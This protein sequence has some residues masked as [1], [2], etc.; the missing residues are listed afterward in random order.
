M[1]IS[2]GAEGRALGE[3][4]SSELTSVPARE[5]EHDVRGVLGLAHQACALLALA[6]VVGEIVVG[7]ELVDVRRVGVDREGVASAERRAALAHVVGGGHVAE[8]QTVE[9]HGLTAVRGSLRERALQGLALGLDDAVDGQDGG[10]LALAVLLV[11]LV[12][13]L[14]GQI[15]H[16]L[17]AELDEDVELAA[18]GQ[19][20]LVLVSTP[21]P[22][23]ELGQLFAD[24]GE[25][26]LG[27]LRLGLGLGVGDGLLASGD[28]LL[29]IVDLLGRLVVGVAADDDAHD[30]VADAVAHD[31]GDGGVRGLRAD[32]RVALLAQLGTDGLRPEAGA[33]VGFDVDGIR[34]LLGEAL[35][36]GVEQRREVLE[37]PHAVLAVLAGDPGARRASDLAGLG[38]AV[39][40]GVL[41][42]VDLRSQRSDRHGDGQLGDPGAGGGLVVHGV[43][44]GSVCVVRGECPE[45]WA[46]GSYAAAV[47]GSLIVVLRAHT[48]GV[49]LRSRCR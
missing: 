10:L 49:V 18:E 8:E 41:V 14:L 32:Q 33:T 40:V 20:V 6:E 9:S 38:P 42:D 21:F 43:L 46:S 45:T 48:V 27:R 30:G 47:V 26:A 24:G 29:E 11:L 1:P 3:E 39:H 25:L 7:R 5:L 13:R 28:G 19:Q 16:G 36:D 23:L 2:L 22:F 4:V 35:L 34:A 17:G 12:L 44:D 37:E 15:V 31:V